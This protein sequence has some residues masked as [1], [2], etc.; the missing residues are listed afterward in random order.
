M[1]PVAVP[2][3]PLFFCTAI[4]KRR[5]QTPAAGELQTRAIV[6][7]GQ[8]QTAVEA[9]VSCL[10]ELAERLSLHAAPEG[11]ENRVFER[12]FDVEDLDADL[13][14]GLSQR[15]KS[16]LFLPATG[17]ASREARAGLN[18]NSMSNRRVGLED[19]RTG[20]Q[21]QLS[22]FCA[23]F[24]EAIRAG[25]YDTVSTSG[26]AVHATPELAFS[27]AI[28]EA[29]ERDVFSRRWYNRLGITEI[30]PARV[31]YYLSSDTWKYLQCRKRQVTVARVQNEFDIHVAVAVSTAEDGYGGALG[32]SA[33][34]SIHQSIE[35]AIMEMLQS[36]FSQNLSV[37]SAAGSGQISKAVRFGRTVKLLE[38]LKIESADADAAKQSDVLYSPSQLLDSFHAAGIE[39]WRFDATHPV[40]NIPCVRVLSP[41]LCTLEPRFGRQRLY[42]ERVQHDPDHMLKHEE[43][44]RNWIF[45]Y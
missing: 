25:L 15:Q 43:L 32:V 39:L 26:A 37:R 19:C 28:L 9:A 3:C 44:Y 33:G 36:E 30:N 40:L 34:W 2:D 11:V 10:G 8:G 29:V 4:W 41:D 21:A 35:G 12:L 5:P 1:R 22:S 17:H 42:P 38:H 27:N 20:R 23:L 24:D 18:L 31:A 7:G 14:L 13:F 16:S 45:P 6:A